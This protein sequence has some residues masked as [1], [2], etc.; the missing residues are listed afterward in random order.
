MALAVPRNVCAKMVPSAITLM[1][2]AF[3]P[4]A[5]WDISVTKVSGSIFDII[6]VAWKL[7]TII[8]NYIGRVRKTHAV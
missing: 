7:D 8:S 6:R 3:A 5:G 4:R 1:E 2:H